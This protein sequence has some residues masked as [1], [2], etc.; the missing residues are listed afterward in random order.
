MTASDRRPCT[1]RYAPTAPLN[2]GGTKPQYIPIFAALALLSPAVWAEDPVTPGK[3]STSTTVPQAQ[4]QAKPAADPATQD[5]KD[6]DFGKA[7]TSTSPS[8]AKAQG[9]SATKPRVETAASQPTANK[10][11]TVPAPPVA[12]APSTAAAQTQPHTS[13]D[14]AAAAA[15]ASTQAAAPVAGNNGAVGGSKASQ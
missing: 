12:S 2:H 7:G 4:S 3:A 14:K 15:A 6:K 9:E 13:G 8:P 5:P 10:E 1:P 11:V